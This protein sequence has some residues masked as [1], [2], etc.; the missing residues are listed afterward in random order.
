VIVRTASRRPG[1]FM[2]G[3]ERQ[4]QR[5][6]WDEYFLKIA[7]D[8]AARADCTRR[9]VGAVLVKRNRVLSTGY[10][11]APAGEPGCLTD[12]ACP[13]G[14]HYSVVTGPNPER[15]SYVPLYLLDCACG[16]EW[17]CPDAAE[18]GSS[19][20]TGPG[21]CRSL[22]AEQNAIIYSS[23]DQCEGAVLYCTEIPCDG[24]MR[25]IRGAGI[26]K[27]VTPEG[28]DNLWENHR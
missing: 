21:A 4:R 20:D 13:R 28:S 26:L 16:N 2:P 6:G 24:C 8:V 1:R 22:H 19:Y 15:G 3:P 18:P 12:R 10:N 27:V 5:P 11:G 14:R 9:Q 7:E 23:R 17:P 25:M